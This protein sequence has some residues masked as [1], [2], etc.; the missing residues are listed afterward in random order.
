MPID[1]EF[2][3][4]GAA[5]C[6]QSDWHRAERARY[7][8]P[9][10]LS[11]GRLTARKGY[12]E[13]FAIYA[14]IARRRPDVSLLII[15]DGPERAAHEAFV[16]S[17]GW[18]RVHFLGFR[19]AG[20]LV[21]YLALADLFIFH[22]LDDPFGAVVSEAMAAG[23]PVVSSI[24][25]AATRDLVDDG[26]TGWRIDPTQAT[27]SADV[28]LRALAL[29]PGERAAVARAASARVKDYD[30]ETA[31]A[32]MVRFIGGLCAPNASGERVVMREVNDG[33]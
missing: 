16:R 4:Q 7:P 28:I 6:R 15:G 24:H 20:E 11:A 12:R 5:A 33:G 17:N 22:T 13:L 21:K 30:I 19:Q 9:L 32:E 26:A 2:F 8:G 31:A 29:A 3:R 10:L 27:V 14:E 23:L 18:T 25:G 1:V